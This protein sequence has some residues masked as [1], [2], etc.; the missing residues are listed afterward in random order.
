MLAEVAQAGATIFDPSTPAGARLD[1]MGQ[2]FTQL[3]DD[4]SGGPAA[5]RFDDMLTLLAALVHAGRPLTADQLAVALAWPT[6]RVARAAHDAAHHPD[7][8]DPV[9]LDHDESG[10]RAIAQAG[11]LSTAQR[12]A[13]RP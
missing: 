13:L 10:Y 4:M 1:S 12:E 11:R 3:S 8:T 6:D 9:R 2:F 7:V 5:D